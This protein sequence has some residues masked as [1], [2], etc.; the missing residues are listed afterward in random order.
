MPGHTDCMVR[1]IPEEMMVL[2]GVVIVHIPVKN[3]VHFIVLITSQ[4]A[5]SL[6]KTLS[7][8]RVVLLF[9]EEFG[10]ST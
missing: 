6:Q 2:V 10:K 5:E 4:L 9:H 7:S 3:W 1:N 8:L